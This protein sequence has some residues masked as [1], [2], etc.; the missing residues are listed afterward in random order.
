MRYHYLENRVS[1]YVGGWFTLLLKTEF[2][3]PVLQ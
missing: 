2:V 1:R 3:L